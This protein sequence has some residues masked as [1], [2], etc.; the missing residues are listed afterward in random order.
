MKVAIIVKPNNGCSFYRLVLPADYMPW[1]ENDSIKIF[2]P[3]HY[4]S[5]QESDMLGH[6]KDIET[7]APDLLFFNGIIPKDLVWLKKMKDQGTKIVFDC[8]DYWEL[9][10]SHPVFKQWYTGAF[11]IMMQGY[12]SIAD[13]VFVPNEYL[14][15]KVLFFNRNCLI[16]PNAVPYGQP[17]YHSSGVKEIGR[18]TTF[19]YSGGSTHYNDLLLLKNKFDKIG[20]DTYLRTNSQ[21]VLAG[22]DPI[23]DKHCEWDKMLSLISRTKN[24]KVIN[25]L[26]VEKHMA[27]YDTSDVV[28][29]PLVDSEFN[30][31]KSFLKVI[32]ASTREL[33]CIVSDVLPYSELKGTKG[34][35]WENWLENIKYCIKNPIFVQDS[36]KEL[37]EQMKTNFNINIWGPTRYQVFKSLLK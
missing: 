11:N 6:I 8:D 15:N 32:E 28:L 26:P 24:F 4:M 7:F 27:I 37:A 17:G 33:P 31:S 21:Y 25:T 12:L 29:I 30:R 20:N 5:L 3:D 22:Y 13:I 14:R 35:M 1:D 16:I 36:G 19:L 18:T 34:L 9:P 10:S 2:Y 23:P